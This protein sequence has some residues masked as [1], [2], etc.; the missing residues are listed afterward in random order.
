MVHIAA[1]NFLPQ[2]P[3][4]GGLGPVREAVAGLPHGQLGAD[5][6]PALEEGQEV[7]QAVVVHQTLA[8]AVVVGDLHSDRGPGQLGPELG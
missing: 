4:P 5:P 7:G 2:P 3:P 6:C 8:Q 1:I